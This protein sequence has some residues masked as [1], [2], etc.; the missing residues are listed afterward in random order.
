ME[1]AKDEGKEEEEP[2]L[3]KESTG[4]GVDAETDAHTLT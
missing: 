2:P 4:E 1:G 3:E